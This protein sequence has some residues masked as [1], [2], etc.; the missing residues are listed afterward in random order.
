[1]SWNEDLNEVQSY[2]Q[3][4]DSCQ[5]HKRHIRV[6]DFI[7]HQRSWLKLGRY[8]RNNHYKWLLQVPV[9]RQHEL[10]SDTAL[11]S[12]DTKHENLSFTVPAKKNSDTNVKVSKNDLLQLTWLIIRTQP[13]VL[14]KTMYDIMVMLSFYDVESRNGF[15]RKKETWNILRMQ[16]ILLLFLDCLQG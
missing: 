10:V 6:N 3:Y 1:M 12:R 9:K 16:K 7:K 2:E 15:T 4:R 11:E 8:T 13:I 5:P 14:G